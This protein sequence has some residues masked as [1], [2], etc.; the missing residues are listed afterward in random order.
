MLR[1]LSHASDLVPPTEYVEEGRL[2]GKTARRL[3][4]LVLERRYGMLPGALRDV[5][6][7]DIGFGVPG[8]VRE[9]IPPRGAFSAGS[10]AAARS[11]VR[12]SSS[13]S[14]AE[15]GPC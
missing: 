2:P 4:R 6:L 12:T 5:D 9:H 10:S 11:A 15:W 13:T 14:A 7:V 3:R 1:D 8:R